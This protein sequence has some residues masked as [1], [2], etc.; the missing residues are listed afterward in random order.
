MYILSAQRDTPPERAHEPY[1][2]PFPA[3]DAYLAA[4]RGR[5]PPGAYAL[6]TGAW[7]YDPRDPRCPH[8]AWLEAA[9]LREPAEGERHEIRTTALSVRLLGAYHDGHIELAYPRVFAYG[10]DARDTAGG[11]GDWRYDEFRVSDRG[12]LIHE[13]E[14]ADG[15][16]WLIEADD[17]EYRWIPLHAGTAG[18][19]SADER[20]G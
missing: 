10:M 6:A 4:N 5:F 15:A 1:H 20:T 16:T 9:I 8:D 7:W 2:D 19:P 17:V 13:I 12:R 18:S 14:W 3:Y 11:H